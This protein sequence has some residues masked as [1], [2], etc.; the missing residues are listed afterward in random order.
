[1]PY[2]NFRPE[3]NHGKNSVTTYNVRLH[4][5]SLSHYVRVGA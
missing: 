3:V 1:M 5:N 4:Y 2:F